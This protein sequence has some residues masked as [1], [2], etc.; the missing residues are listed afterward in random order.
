AVHAAAVDADIPGAGRIGQT[1]PQ[2]RV[3]EYHLLLPG[4]AVIGDPLPSPQEVILGVIAQP[5]TAQAGV[6]DQDFPGVIYEGEGSEP[7]DVILHIRAVQI[8]ASER[9]GAAVPLPTR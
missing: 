7:G 9:G 5:G 3:A 6:A 4:L 2:R 1:C 8:I